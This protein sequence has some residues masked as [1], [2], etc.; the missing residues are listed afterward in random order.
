MVDAEVA[1]ETT[2]LADLI[3]GLGVK[4][5][6][7]E[8]ERPKAVT[9]SMILSSMV[10]A[11]ATSSF[12]EWLRD[13]KNS[14]R[15]PHQFEQCGYVAFRNDADKRDGIWVIDGKRQVVYVQ[16]ELTNQEA[17]NAINELKTVEQR[18]KNKAREGVADINKYR[19]EKA[20]QAREPQ[21]RNDEATHKSQADD[22]D[23]PF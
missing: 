15:I 18:A 14:R 3:D 6:N 21:P 12:Y 23:T 20:A 11:G 16:R 8:V 10:K 2:E 9:V 17:H 1:V 13:R 5:A 4:Q 22:D 19:E 7:G